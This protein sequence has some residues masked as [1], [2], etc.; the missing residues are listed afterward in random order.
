MI[1]KKKMLF[2]LHDGVDIKNFK[3]KN[4]KNN[5]KNVIYIGS[6]YKGRGIN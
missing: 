3:N 1:N 6:F 4:T 2:F 5:L